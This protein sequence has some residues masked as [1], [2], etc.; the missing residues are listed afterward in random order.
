MSIAIPIFLPSKSDSLKGIFE[1][2]R[3]IAAINEIVAISFPY[4]ILPIINP[5]IIAKLTINE[6]LDKNF[7]P[8]LRF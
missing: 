6:K 4:G 5:E 8:F 2:E 7:I 1:I 3:V